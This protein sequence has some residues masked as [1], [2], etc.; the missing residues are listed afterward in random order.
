MTKHQGAEHVSSDDELNA[1]KAECEKEIDLCHETINENQEDYDKQLLTLGSAFIVLVIGF[2][3]DVV[4]LKSAHYIWLFNSTLALFLACIVCV[5]FSYQLSIQGHF[6]AKKF[7]EEKQPR[8]D[9]LKFPYQFAIYVRQVNMLS[10]A[11]FFF[12][13]V[14]LICFIIA[15]VGT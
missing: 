3:K 8:E 12:A 11:L 6:K 7:W 4:P 5:L 10:G 2:V 15:N 1:H 13:I 14:A 9:T